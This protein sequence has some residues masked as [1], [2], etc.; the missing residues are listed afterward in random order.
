MEEM[1]AALAAVRREDFE[2]EEEYQAE[3]DRIRAYYMG[4]DL[5]FRSEID[6]ALQNSGKVYAEITLGQLENASSL[7]QGHQNLAQS[8]NTAIED[9]VTAWG[10]WKAS[11]D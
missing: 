7:D 5:Y 4:R 2:S 3:L 9:M 11:V 8:V 1:M 6:K 10:E